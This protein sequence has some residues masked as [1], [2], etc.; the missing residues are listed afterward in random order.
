MPQAPLLKHWPS[1]FYVELSID[2]ILIGS[3]GII[4]AGLSNQILRNMRSVPR[5]MK[6]FENEK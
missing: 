1:Y 2:V 4:T 3:P 5:R 6:N